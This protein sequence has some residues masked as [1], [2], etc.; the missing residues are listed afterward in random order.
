MQNRN[1]II[2]KNSYWKESIDLIDPITHQDVNGLNNVYENLILLIL[3]AFWPPGHS[4]GDCCGH[5][6]LSNLQ[7]GAFLC[8]VSIW[9]SGI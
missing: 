5:L 7:L 9:N 4:V 2:Q 8:N 3:N 1:N 6:G